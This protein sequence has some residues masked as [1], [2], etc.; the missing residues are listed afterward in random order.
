MKSKG[1]DFGKYNSL[2]Y[3]IC[4]GLTEDGKMDYSTP[5]YE[6][7]KY[8]QC[9]ACNRRFK[10]NE[11]LQNSLTVITDNKEE[12]PEVEKLIN[13]YSCNKDHYIGRKFISLINGA[14]TERFYRR[15]LQHE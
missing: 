9:E 3:R 15:R 11:G 1:C 8:C 2:S 14:I 10:Y 13:N 12:F 4:C 7:H 5:H 6:F